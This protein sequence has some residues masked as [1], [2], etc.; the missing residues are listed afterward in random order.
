MWEETEMVIILI[1]K[2][3]KLSPVPESGGRWGGQADMRLWGCTGMCKQL[4]GQEGTKNHL[5]KGFQAKRSKGGRTQDRRQTAELLAVLKRGWAAASYL[6][7]TLCQLQRVH[8]SITLIY[9]FE[10]LKTQALIKAIIK[11]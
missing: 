11:S 5:L 8:P 6:F 7:I 9:R 2:K 3:T 4:C 1:H 10:H